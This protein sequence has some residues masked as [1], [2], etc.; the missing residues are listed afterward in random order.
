MTCSCRGSAGRRDLGPGRRAAV[1]KLSHYLGGLMVVPLIGRWLAAV[2]GGLLVLVVWGSVIG[3][4]IVP[5]PVG[6][7]LTRWVDRLVNGAFGL[8]TAAIAD[9]RRRDQVLVGQ[10]AAI[11][12]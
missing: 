1:V 3:T 7:R 5:R 11:L 12:P 9:Y 10:A 6:S 4:L 8:V 2:A